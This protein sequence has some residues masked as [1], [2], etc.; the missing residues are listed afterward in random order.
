MRIANPIFGLWM[1]AD[2]R[3]ERT[4]CAPAERF[5]GLLQWMNRAQIPASS[6]AAAANHNFGYCTAPS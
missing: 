6:I 3:P 4:A 2:D 5:K 1:L